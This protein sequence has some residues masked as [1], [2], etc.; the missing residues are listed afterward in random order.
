MKSLI[1]IVTLSAGCAGV[2]TAE[3]CSAGQCATGYYD[4]S[5]NVVTAGHPF[6]NGAEAEVRGLGGYVDRGTVATRENDTAEIRVARKFPRAVCYSSARTGEAVTVSTSYG[7]IR[8]RVARVAPNGYVLAATLRPGNSGAPVTRRG[9]VVGFIHGLANG[10]GT[11]A[12]LR[13]K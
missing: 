6:V 2:N 11:V 7:P 12:L 9:C 10:G 13:M 3:V 8:T 1:L 5:G 4:E